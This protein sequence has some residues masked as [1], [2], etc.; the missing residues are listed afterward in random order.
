M[1][2]PLLSGVTLRAEQN[3][4]LESAE[5]SGQKLLDTS[6]KSMQ[7]LVWTQR[8]PGVW[9][10]SFGTPEIGPMQYAGAPQMNALKELGEPEFPSAIPTVLGDAKNCYANV[11]IPLASTE[12]FM[13]SG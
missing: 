12:K 5:K 4:A 8:A 3:P 2:A 13:V 7:K 11:I 10:A 1:L 6:M 9:S